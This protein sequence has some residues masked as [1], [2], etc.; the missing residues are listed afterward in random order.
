[1]IWESE[2]YYLYVNRNDCINH[3]PIQHSIHFVV[4]NCHTVVHQ[5]SPHDDHI[6]LFCII[7]LG[8]VWY[9]FILL[10]FMGKNEG[11]K[12]TNIM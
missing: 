12:K 2:V 7:P 6:H 8:S 5:M 3:Y 11:K 4:S 9:I 10:L 1:M